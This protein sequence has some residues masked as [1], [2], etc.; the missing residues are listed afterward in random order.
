MSTALQRVWTCRSKNRMPTDPSVRR[1]LRWCRG[2]KSPRRVRWSILYS[3]F[4]CQTCQ[5]PVK[6][7]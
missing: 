3:V 7:F 2:H 4:I 6:G 5:R 1:R